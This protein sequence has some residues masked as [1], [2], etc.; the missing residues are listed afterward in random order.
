MKLT[1]DGWMLL[2]LSTAPNR[3][4][5][6]QH[7]SNRTARYRLNFRTSGERY[8]AR[9]DQVINVIGQCSCRMKDGLERVR[10]ASWWAL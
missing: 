7:Q 8:R 9:R 3:S 4:Q 5:L 10:R 1:K 6:P 2:P